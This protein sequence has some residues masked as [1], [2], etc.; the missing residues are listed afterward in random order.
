MAVADGAR[1]RQLIDLRSHYDHT[2]YTV[3]E[4][5][6]LY[7][8]SRLFMSMGLRHLCVLDASSHVVGIITRKDLARLPTTYGDSE[9]HLNASKHGATVMKRMLDARHQASHA[10]VAR[11][12]RRTSD[13]GVLPRTYSEPSNLVAT[14]QR[15]RPGEATLCS[16]SKGL[17]HLNSKNSESFKKM[18]A[19][20]RQPSQAKLRLMKR[21]ASV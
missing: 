19:S 17:A 3:H 10:Q 16:E 20:K 21:R 6:P 9:S 15:L 8:V 11:H 13:P 18:M 14:P 7:R 5:L 1:R 12:R 4:L 2:P